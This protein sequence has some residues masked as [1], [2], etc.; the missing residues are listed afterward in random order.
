L[1]KLPEVGAYDALVIGGPVR[2]FAASTVLA[3]FFE[4]TGLFHDK[5]AVCFVTH[6]FPYPWLGGTRAIAQIRK[7]CESK[8]VTVIGTGII[9]WKSSRREEEIIDV[10]ERF[11][12]LF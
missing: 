6:L 3:A 12:R 9:D 8:G 11:N 1:R 4:Q 2:G 7:F 5:K 10:I